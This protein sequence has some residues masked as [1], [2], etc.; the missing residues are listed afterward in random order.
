[1]AKRGINIIDLNNMG[2]L[3]FLLALYPILG[4]YV[5]GWLHLDLLI[6]LILDFLAFSKKKGILKCKPLLWFNI[7]VI[8]HE[9]FV[10]ILTGANNQTHL[11]YFISIVI[12][13]LSIFVV[14][15]ALD[16]KKFSNSV[17][18]ISV[19]CMIGLIYHF[20][21]IQ[22]GHSVS[23][24]P[25]LPDLLGESSRLHEI[26]E[27]PV[28][29]FWEPSG[30]ITYMMIPLFLSLI[31][32]NF[33]WSA[34]I[35]FTVLL[36]TSTNGI[37][38]SFILIVGYVLTQKIGTK[39]KLIM[40]VFGVAFAYFL[41]NSSL[42]ESGV[43]KINETDYEHT[44]RLYNGPTI[45]ANLPTNHLIL[46]IPRFNVY[47]YYS[48]TSYLGATQLLEKDDEI[49]LPTLYFIITKYGLVTLAIYIWLLVYIFKK[50]R[51]IWPYLIVIVVGMFSQIA[52]LNLSWT[53]S[54]IFML[55]FIGYEAK[56][57]NSIIHPKYIKN[58]DINANN[59]VCK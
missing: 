30:Y 32:R 22:T 42:F 5:F 55:C 11:N 24:I 38:F 56:F 27:R 3:E 23:P 36:S 39:Y 28:S 9:I 45:V 12:F 19:F 58:E 47:E 4:Q 15:P 25:I 53:Y 13:L 1:M 51:K 43:E 20:L 46:G 33:V 14:V 34:I 2:G 40:V 37:V 7:F 21:L 57:S 17:N 8:A 18:F 52:V 35:M 31:E 54:M 44:S 41:I 48:K 29:F 49:F 6:L 50:D 59:A 26:G 16:F 10:Y